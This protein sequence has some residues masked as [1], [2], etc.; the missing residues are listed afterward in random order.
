MTELSAFIPQPLDFHRVTR[1]A[2]LAGG[3]SSRMGRDKALLPFNNQPLVAH[4][5]QILAP[6][7]DEVIVVTTN[8]QIAEAAD[9][10]AVADTF[11]ARGPLGGIHA[12][13]SHFGAPTFVVACDM[14]HL[15]AAFIRH[16]TEDFEGAARVPLSNDGFEPLHAIYAP[17]CL[18]TF[19][20]Y[21]QLEGK[22]PSM[23]RVLEKV[24]ASW[25]TPEI[26][27]SFDGELK[28]FDNWNTPAD[29]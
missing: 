22:M 7:F 20:R 28:M 12:A 8:P 18:P 24:G 16:L 14:P 5:A 2:I 10:P 29:V 17:A 19:E 9:L 4:I 13:L 11:L 15:N 26:A 21:L 6:I 1:A 3:R 25:I 27:R 23:R